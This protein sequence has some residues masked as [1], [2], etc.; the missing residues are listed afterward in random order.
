MNLCKYTYP[1]SVIA[2]TK[3]DREKERTIQRE[4]CKKKERKNWKREKDVSKIPVRHE[5]M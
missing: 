2:G 1:R 4:I 3:R 5:F